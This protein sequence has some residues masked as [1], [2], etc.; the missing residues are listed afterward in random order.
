[1]TP[2]QTERYLRDKERRQRNGPDTFYV[3]QGGRGKCRSSLETALW[4]QGR[5][6]ALDEGQGV[7]RSLT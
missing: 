3:L 2:E 7:P 1:M 4:M 6:G 5:P